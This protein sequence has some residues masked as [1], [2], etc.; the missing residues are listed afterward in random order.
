MNTGKVMLPLSASDRELCINKSRRKHTD[1]QTH[2]QTHTHTQSHKHIDKQPE[3]GGAVCENVYSRLELTPCPGD[4]H[5][6]ADTH[7]HSYRLTCSV[8]DDIRPGMFAATH[9]RLVMASAG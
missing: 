5:T 7:T 8:N 1:T 4:T 2:R 3:T 9:A 6:H